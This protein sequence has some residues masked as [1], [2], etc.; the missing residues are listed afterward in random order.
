MADLKLT[1][2]QLARFLPDHQSI[3]AFEQLLDDVA[4]TIPEAGDEAN[5]NAGIAIAVAN[6]ALAEVASIIREL[7]LALNAPVV[8]P[9]V[10]QDDVAPRLEIGTLASQNSD[11]V[12]ITGGSIDGVTLGATTPSSAIFTSVSYSGQLTSTV[13]TGTAP[14][15]ITS[16]TKVANLNADLLDGGDWATPGSIGV[17]TP[18]GGAFTSL[19]STGAPSFGTSS[20]NNQT[21]IRGS[22]SGTNGGAAVL[23]LN[24]GATIIG[25]GN[26]SVILGGAYDATPFIYANANIEI[27]QSVKVPGGAVFLLTSSS[28]TNGAGA[29]AG[30]ITNAPAAGNP[31]KWIGINDNGTIR[32]IPA[33]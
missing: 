4:V 24:G 3:R 1:R 18:N 19:S 13:T 6:A 29:G 33:W 9:P 7:Q 25:A 30:T 14:M 20:L 17:T 28:L 31:T 27:N 22:S 5:T 21:L 26:K 23:I 15:V 10:F 32:Y 11:T 16:T 12:S 8:Q 2:E